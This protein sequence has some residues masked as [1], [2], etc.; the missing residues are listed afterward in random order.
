LGIN[1][2]LYDTC[3]TVA[4]AIA[5]AKVPDATRLYLM[6]HVD[7]NVIRRYT[8]LQGEDCREDLE[9]A[10]K[11]RRNSSGVPHSFHH[12]QEKPASGDCD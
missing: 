9:R 1:Y 3:H 8:H 5:M 12:S 6:G 4:T 7:E 11:M 10:L 2:R